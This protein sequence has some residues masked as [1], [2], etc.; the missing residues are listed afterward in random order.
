MRIGALRS[1]TVK[2]NRQRAQPQG[3]VYNLSPMDAWA[4]VAVEWAAPMA[5]LK[6]AQPTRDMPLGRRLVPKSRRACAAGM[7]VLA[8]TASGVRP[9]PHVCATGN[10]QSVSLTY[11]ACCSRIHLPAGDWELAGLAEPHRRVMHCCSYSVDGLVRRSGGWTPL[12][13]DIW[14]AATPATH[15]VSRLRSSESEQ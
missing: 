12:I 14:A 4:V 5:T 3:A 7:A 2:L 1:E 9:P 6:S 15:G 13:E 11:L 8:T 10:L